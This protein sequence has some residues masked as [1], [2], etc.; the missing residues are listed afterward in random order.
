MGPYTNDMVSSLWSFLGY[1]AGVFIATVVFPAFLA[2]IG[3]LTGRIVRKASAGRLPRAGAIG[4]W[5]AFLL[6]LGIIE[7]GMVR[8]EMVESFGRGLYGWDETGAAIGLLVSRSL[9][10]AVAGAIVGL[11]FRG[12][13]AARRA[14][15]AAGVLAGVVF[16]GVTFLLGAVVASLVAQGTLGQD[17]AL[18]SFFFAGAFSVAKYFKPRRR[19]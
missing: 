2:L 4:A 12:V 17:G 5:A 7:W 18:M 1:S 19:T 16:L 14:A 10:V 8:N 15:V 3:W 11:A 9:T 13:R 6:G